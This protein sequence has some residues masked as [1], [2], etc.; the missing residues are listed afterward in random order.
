MFND[1]NLSV[2]LVSIASMVIGALIRGG[3]A[4][5]ERYFQNKIETAEKILKALREKQRIIKS[6]YEDFYLGSEEKDDLVK[7]IKK[8]NGFD[9]EELQY[10]FELYYPKQIR[11]LS[12]IN[13][14]A[15]Y[16][17]GELIKNMSEY[18]K[19][20]ED[21]ER[22]GY[23]QYQFRDL[24]YSIDKLIFSIRGN[25]NPPLYRIVDYYYRSTGSYRSWKMKRHNKKIQKQREREK[26]KAELK[27]KNSLE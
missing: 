16:S 15:Y 5:H 11:N 17:R 2:I 8:C 3:A 10:L 14:E 6:L 22:A 26:L 18:N 13:L 9:F 20:D 23:Y 19:L 7:K 12:S 27:I 1:F 21:M 25:V 4:Q 24:E